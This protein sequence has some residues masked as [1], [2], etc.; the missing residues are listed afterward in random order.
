MTSV[1]YELIPRYNL[2]SMSGTLPIIYVVPVLSSLLPA[3]SSAAF[4]AFAACKVRQFVGS[5][6]GSF[7]PLAYSDAAQATLAVTSPML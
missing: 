2:S 7:K 5:Q 3:P 1:T 6:R 4:T